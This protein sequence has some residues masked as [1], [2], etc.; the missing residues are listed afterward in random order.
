MST[1]TSS[2]DDDD[3]ES[4][5][6]DGDHDSQCRGKA[7]SQGRVR[8]ACKGPRENR[9]ELAA[10]V[11]ACTADIP[12]TLSS[13]AVGT[14][15]GR[16]DEKSRGRCAERQR[17]EVLV[18]LDGWGVPK[19]SNSPSNV[20]RKVAR[21]PIATETTWTTEN[22]PRQPPARLI[23][24]AQRQR[25]VCRNLRRPNWLRANHPL[26]SQPGDPPRHHHRRGVHARSRPAAAA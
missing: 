3:D 7:V 20:T 10:L 16:E 6:S 13:A 17:V 24:A 8:N 18:C 11:H 5:E 1:S 26:A 9:T 23:G 14:C 25:D 15:F 19:L 22:N 2:T 4:D 21:P 12:E